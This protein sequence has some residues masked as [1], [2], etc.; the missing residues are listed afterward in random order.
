MAKKIPVKELFNYIEMM[1]RDKWGYIWGTAGVMWTQA[2][3]NKVTDERAQMY[4]DKWIGHMVTDCSGVM[5]YIWKKFGLDIL[6]GSNSIAKRGYIGKL[7]RTPEP[8]FAAFKYRPGDDDYYHIGIVGAD[9]A[10]VYEA[11][12]TIEGFTTS[13]SS[14]WDYFAPFKDVDYT[15]ESEVIPVD[16]YYA[17]ITGDNVRIRSG[18]GTTYKKIGDNLFKGDI[19]KV[20]AEPTENW[21][22]AQ[23]EGQKIQGYIFSKYV[24]KIDEPAE[25]PGDEYHEVEPA[26]PEKPM[27][28]LDANVALAMY[29]VLYIALK[30]KGLLN[31]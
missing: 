2:R 31:D 13:K 29:D 7:Q 21:V 4:G 17:K 24:E 10:T 26:D 25:E 18:P 5:V 22:F 11:K 6:H 20:V 16:P 30:D 14:A 23:V 19:V 27:I 9:G 15:V 3:Q 8:G 1:L 28:E 12:G